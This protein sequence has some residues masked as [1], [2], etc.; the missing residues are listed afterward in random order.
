MMLSPTVV[1][2]KL[3]KKHLVLHEDMNLTDQ[4]AL[5]GFW[6]LL[7]LIRRTMFCTA[8]WRHF[9]FGTSRGLYFRTTQSGV[10]SGILKQFSMAERFSRRFFKMEI[11]HFTKQQLCTTCAVR[12]S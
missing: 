2:L 3:R 8:Q 10:L 4:R 5:E 1:Y 11:R 9:W 6:L 7:L 12:Q